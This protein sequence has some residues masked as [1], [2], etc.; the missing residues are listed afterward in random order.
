M[1][2]PD[3]HPKTLGQLLGPQNESWQTSA[4]SFR[5]LV[6]GSEEGCTSVCVF[7]FTS[8]LRCNRYGEGR[9]REGKGSTAL[10]LNNLVTDKGGVKFCL[11][12][13][14]SH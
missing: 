14:F 10:H 1:P 5:S 12:I 13:L 3:P 9:G 2:F 8:F 4:D 11:M 7:S 6:S